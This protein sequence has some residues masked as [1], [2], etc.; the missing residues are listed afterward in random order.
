MI[1]SPFSIQNVLYEKTDTAY[2]IEIAGPPAGVPESFWNKKINT[3]DI[4]THEFEKKGVTTNLYS[5]KITPEIEPYFGLAGSI[6]K[7]YT[8]SKIF[9]DYLFPT[10]A[11]TRYNELYNSGSNRTFGEVMQELAYEFNQSNSLFLEGYELVISSKGINFFG[12]DN[13]TETL[14]LKISVSYRIAEQIGSGTLV[15][16]VFDFQRVIY[17]AP[18][19]IGLQNL[20]PLNSAFVCPTIYNKGFYN[21]K[22][23]I[24]SKFV[25]WY[26]GKISKYGENT[27]RNPTEYTLVPM[28]SLH[29][30]VKQFLTLMNYKEVGQFFLDETFKQLIIENTSSIDK[31]CESCDLTFNIFNTKIDYKTHLPNFTVQEFFDELKQH[32]GLTIEYDF[33]NR[34]CKIDFI[35]PILDSIENED[36]SEKVGKVVSLETSKI[37]KIQF[38]YANSFVPDADKAHEIN[39]PIPSDELVEIS[40]D[41]YTVFKSKIGSLPVQVFDPA[42][43]TIFIRPRGNGVPVSGPGT[44]T[45]TTGV[46]RMYPY[47]NQLGNSVLYEQDKQ[48]FGMRL[49]IFIGK[50]TDPQGVEIIRADYKNANLNLSLSKTDTNSRY[51]RFL[52]AYQNYLENAVEAETEVYLTDAEL[53]SFNWRKK[54]YIRGIHYLVHQLLPTLPIKKVFRM[55]MKRY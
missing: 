11:S 30:V 9:V 34:K 6:V 36:F 25:N 2:S 19:L 44:T 48:E 24:W 42:I 3:V 55:K 20:T 38:G 27:F 49:L 10:F 43:E 13:L 32:F 4:G 5:L 40:T 47:C 52:R 18:I 41:D 26:D 37:K 35:Q 31:Q 22:N 29:Y 53:G 50:Q 21:E 14:N 23:K 33:I 46:I 39:L 16:K 45:V 51:N 12:P 28:I 7:I 15:T 8:G 17:L 54:K 1:W